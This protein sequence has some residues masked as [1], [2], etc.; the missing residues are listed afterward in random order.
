MPTASVRL[1]F[2]AAVLMLQAGCAK[3]PESTVK[4]FYT[5]LGKGET[6][7]AL[8]YL[9][10]QVTGML[11]MDKARATLAK[12]SERIQGCGGFK[13][14]EVR[15]EG[16]GDVRSGDATVSFRGEC[17]PKRERLKLVK[18]DGRW[19]LGATK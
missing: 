9:S 19:R 13:S 17:P 1:L 2:C 5:A 15:L 10:S 4:A 7:E 18:E 14:I 11:G 6:T 3:S 8:G 16:E 12:E